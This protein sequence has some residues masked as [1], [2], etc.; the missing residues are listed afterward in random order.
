MEER[1]NYY[2][3]IPANIRYDNTLPPNAKL[4]Y[5]EITALCN[6]DGY[7]HATNEYFAKLYSV[8]TRTIT[9]W[10]K[11]LEKGVPARPLKITINGIAGLSN[12]TYGTGTN[13]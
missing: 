10:I 11:K 1:P 3:I 9:E 12:A 13:N 7:C 5:G 2:A 8:S 4:L 6:K